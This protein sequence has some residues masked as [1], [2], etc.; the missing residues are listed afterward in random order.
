MALRRKHIGGHP[1]RR[2]QDGN[3]RY[4][5]TKEIVDP[6]NRDRPCPV[7]GLNPKDYGNHDPCIAN[8]PGV[9]R[10]CC[11]HGIKNKGSL[12]F[13]D[14]TLITGT[15]KVERRDLTKWWERHK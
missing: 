8:L 14:G 9:I 15:F 6:G 3:W 2:D 4:K 1:A 11:G 13:E 10:A 5:D 7:C 12:L